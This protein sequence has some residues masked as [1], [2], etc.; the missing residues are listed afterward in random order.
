MGA[1]DEIGTVLFHGLARQSCGLSVRLS[2][3]TGRAWFIG[4]F[5]ANHGGTLLKLH[6]YQDAEE[7]LVEAYEILMGSVGPE[8]QYTIGAVE[9]FAD[10]YTAWHEAE[11]D[12]GYDAKA[13]EWR[14]KLPDEMNFSEQDD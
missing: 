4:A 14:A 1:R 3:G 5:R 8:N 6:R 9:S 7:A 10:L 12:K 13:A 11:P 2:F